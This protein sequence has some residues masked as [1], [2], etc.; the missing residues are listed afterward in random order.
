MNSWLVALAPPG[1]EAALEP[2]GEGHFRV[3]GGEEVLPRVVAFG[4]VID[5]RAVRA[6]CDGAELYRTFDC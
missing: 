2:L 4:D 5:G 3:E 6:S 1:V